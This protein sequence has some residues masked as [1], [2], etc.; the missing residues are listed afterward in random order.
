MKIQ[1]QK[2]QGK[3]NCVGLNVFLWGTFHN[4]LEMFIASHEVNGT[5]YPIK[6]VSNS[7]CQTV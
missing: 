5:P 7:V 4:E 3:C 1:K 2:I 6:S